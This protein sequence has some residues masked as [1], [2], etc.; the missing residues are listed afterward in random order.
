MKFTRQD[1]REATGNAA[2]SRGR[3]Y[4]ERGRVVHFEV[5]LAGDQVYLRAETL[6]NSKRSY[7]QDIQLEQL[8]YSV[9]IDGEC[10]CPVGYN[11]KHIAAV[12]LCF[13]HNPNVA[14][15]ARGAAASAMQ[16]WLDEFSAS[17]SLAVPAA[18]TRTEFVAY[19]LIPQHAR[20]PDESETVMIEARVVKRKK[21][22]SG[23]TRGR[24]I[25]LHSLRYDHLGVACATRSDRDIA[26]L[27]CAGADGWQGSLLEGELGHLA[28][29]RL[30]DSG[31]CFWTSTEQPPLAR[32]TPRALSMEWVMQAENALLEL[33]LKVAGNA[34]LLP[35]E[36]P[37]YLDPLS[38]EIGA[39]DVAGLKREH[40]EL[41]QRA[42]VVPAD[43]AE[44]FSSLLTQRCPDL[45]IPLPKP[46]PIRDVAAEP[47]IPCLTL[48]ADMFDAQEQ[49]VLWLDFEYAGI[50]VPVFPTMPTT[51]LEGVDGLVR[52]ARDLD[53]EAARHDALVALGFMPLRS[54][55]DDQPIVP[56]AYV[57]AG[58]TA[59][60]R[61]GRWSRF[62]QHDCAELEADG[63]QITTADSFLFSFERGALQAE[64]STDGHG[65]DWFEL[66]FE[67]KV[68]EQ[69][70]PLLDAIAPLLETDWSVLPETVTIAL[71]DYRFVDIPGQRLRPVLD[72]LQSLFEGSSRGPGETLKLS[73]YDAARLNELE[74]QGVAIKGNE[75][76]KDLAHRLADFSGIERVAIPEGFT[77]E[78]RDYQQRGL[79]WLQFLRAYEFNGVLADDMGLGKTVQA[80]AH[81][82]VEKNA[83]RLL[84]PALLVA[85]TSLMG[86]WQREAARFTPSLRVVVLHGSDRHRHFGAL[87]DN[88]LVL[89]T[90]ALLPRDAKQLVAQRF[91]SVILDEAQMVK[92]PRAKAAQLIRQLDCA[93][94]LCLTGTPMENHLGELWAQFDFLMPG[95]L[96]DESAFK[97]H[98]RTP[99]ER[100]GDD[101]LRRRLAQRIKPF[102][103]RR[104]KSEVASE[105][106]P[107]T[108]IVQ[109]ASFA[110]AQAE[111]YESIRVAMHDKVRAAIARQGLQR[112]HI[113]ILDALL[114]LRQTCCDPRLLP[115]E[116][117][118]RVTASA[119]FELLFDLLPAQLEEG[120]RILLFSQFTS[121]LELIEGE[122]A[123][124]KIAYTKLT[125]KTRKRDEAIARF[126]AGEVN[127]FL[128]SLKAGGVGLNLSEA[129]TVIH[130]D[131]WWNPAVEAQATDRAHRIGQQQPVFVY[132]LIIENSV[133]EKLL[134]LQ[135]KKRALAEGVYG[136]TGGTPILDFGA[137]ELEELLGPL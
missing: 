130:Y 97:R 27:L 54:A 128:I 6:G 19:L 103:L 105:L 133:E 74:Q 126:T 81:L 47:P 107:K 90:Y 69:T 131:P 24:R 113:T 38:G 108:E 121:M 22:G 110:A 32:G 9:S 80:L 85:P 41:L 89:T 35:T 87:A 59:L 76:L 136:Q 57:P 68:G 71:G 94:R 2:Y 115:L 117:A 93:H 132:K 66:G 51:V 124:R 78:L 21:D 102:M 36:P 112:S 118:R 72:T 111:L 101:D 98:Y 56:A 18:G 109:V 23:L 12:C 31:C 29:Q 42:P 100:H 86:N 28:L 60:E 70:L 4:F 122:L 20:F 62:I 34:L 84:E 25:E 67:L 45:A 50:H 58:T 91:H 14:D 96:G 114:K 73:R 127:L 52:I 61:A 106:P 11:C 3:D 88:D 79:D 135:A 15:I 8:R 55:E 123:K 99:I 43:Q 13:Q 7:V 46:I 53:S 83:G 44:E 82:L 137:R 1:I 125:G 95:F 92:N 48:G 40:I 77:A 37:S 64:L 16:R 49:H 120:R 30:V 39:V 134:E 26:R 104:S 63:W 10:S 116:I 65:L 75:H 5:E 17:Q 33:E 119:K 129:D